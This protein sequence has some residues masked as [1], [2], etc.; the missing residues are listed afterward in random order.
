M[1]QRGFLK[2]EENIWVVYYS[3]ITAD[4]YE[5]DPEDFKQKR[6]RVFGK[7]DE[8][9]IGKFQVVHFDFIEIDGIKMA[10]INYYLMGKHTIDG[11]GETW[12]I[13]YN[14]AKELDQDSFVD[15]MKSKF[16]CP[17]YKV[18]H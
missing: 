18:V 6:I 3:H 5:S 8:S 7:V 12:T 10:K 9:V 13:I 2:N 14:K 1:N 15:L 4:S 11:I 17:G 16:L